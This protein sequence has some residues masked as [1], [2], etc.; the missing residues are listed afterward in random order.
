MAKESRTDAAERIVKGWIE[1]DGSNVNILFGR[2][3]GDNKTLLESALITVALN[4][5]IEGERRSKGESK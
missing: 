2:T 3:G 5:I 4:G 1:S